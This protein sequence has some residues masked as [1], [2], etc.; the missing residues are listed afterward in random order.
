[1]LDVSD[2]KYAKELTQFFDMILAP[3][4]T[5]MEKADDIAIILDM[6]GVTLKEMDEKIEEGVRNGYSVEKQLFIMKLIIQE[7][8]GRR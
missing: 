8:N 7:L 5:P 3:G 6:A 2:L 4:L 1:M